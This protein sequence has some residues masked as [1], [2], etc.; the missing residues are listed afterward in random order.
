MNKLIALGRIYKKG[1][2][3]DTKTGGKFLPFRLMDQKT[4]NNNT[5]YFNCVA[6][7]K[8][9]ELIDTYCDNGDLIFVWGSL[10]KRGKDNEFTLTVNEFYKANGKQNKESSNKDFEEEP[11]F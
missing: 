8:T 3:S 7:D 1:S 5:F 10:A 11:I 9:A 6:F 4:E 2:P